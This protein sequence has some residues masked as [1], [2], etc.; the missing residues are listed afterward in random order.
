VLISITST[1]QR[2]VVEPWAYLQDMLTRLP[3]TLAEQRAN[4]LPDHWQAARH[5][6]MAA[7]SVSASEK[8]AEQEWQ[9]GEHYLAMVKCR[10]TR[11]RMPLGLKA[12]MELAGKV[13]YQHTEEYNY[14]GAAWSPPTATPSPTSRA[15][16]G[17]GAPTA[18]DTIT[19]RRAAGLQPVANPLGPDDSFDS[20]EPVTAQRALRGGS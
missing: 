15:M 16:S 7:P 12:S 1:C 3:T 5:A 14:P 18:T 10:V 4:R 13:P 20:T 11:A 2:L 6:Q 17:S 8:P 19:T 9:Q